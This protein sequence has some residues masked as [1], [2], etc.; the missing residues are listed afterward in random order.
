MV[1]T[2]NNLPE[3]LKNQKDGDT[4]LEF[5][6]HKPFFDELYQLRIAHTH[7]V[8]EFLSDDSSMTRQEILNSFYALIDWTNAQIKAYGGNVLSLKKQISNALLIK[9]THQ[10][11]EALDSVYQEISHI[12]AQ[13]ELLPKVQKKNNYENQKVKFW[14]EEETQAIK[15]LKKAWADVFIEEF[16]LDANRED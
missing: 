8:A 6:Q 4:S 15:E 3:N 11:Y 13:T 9:D 10:C 16:G 5:K 1:W 7:K 2:K 12:Q 14:V